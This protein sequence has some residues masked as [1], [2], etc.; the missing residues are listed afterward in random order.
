MTLGQ[1]GE[2]F[3]GLRG[4]R[5]LQSSYIAMKPTENNEEKSG[6]WTYDPVRLLTL[7]QASRYLARSE[8]SLRTLVYR[9]VFPVVKEGPRS[10]MWIDIRD[11]D[12]WI[13]SKKRL[14]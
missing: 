7:Q 8:A 10:K 13:D 6:H 12:N 9:H 4:S 3:Q 1:V 11:L 2:A 5:E 14:L